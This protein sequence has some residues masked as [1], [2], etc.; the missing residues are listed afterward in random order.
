MAKTKKEKAEALFAEAYISLAHIEYNLS[1][2]VDTEPLI[3]FRKA[4]YLMEMDINKYLPSEH[5]RI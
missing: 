2:S 4:L 1:G 5:G 3:A